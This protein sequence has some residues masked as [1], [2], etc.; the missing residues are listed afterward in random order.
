MTENYRGIEHVWFDVILNKRGLCVYKTQ[1]K[2][3]KT[4]LINTILCTSKLW[5][6]L[7]KVKS[8][9]DLGCLQ[10]QLSNKH[11]YIRSTET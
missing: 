10:V 1:S 5:H 9:K 2:Q 4:S 3:S 11:F 7:I 6:C 8:I